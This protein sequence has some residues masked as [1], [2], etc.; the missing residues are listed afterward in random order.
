MDV[1]ARLDALADD[2]IGTRCCRRD[3]VCEPPDLIQH[4]A[5]GGARTPDEVGTDIPEKAEGMHFSVEA[6]RQFLLEQGG[7]RAEGNQV[8]AEIPIR[9]LA[10]G[11]NF[12][13]DE[14]RR[15]PDHAEQSVAAGRDDRR[16]QLRTR[17]AAHAGGDDG[18]I[19]TQQAACL[20][21]ERRSMR[22]PPP[23][24]NSGSAIMGHREAG[25]H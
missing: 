3:G 21:L 8:Y 20:R 24:D 25:Q 1:P 7:I 9:A 14:L 19:A 12:P 22:H 6:G 17:D 16:H 10:H 23:L 18:V 5:T 2:D 13:A 4:L 15:L 11:R